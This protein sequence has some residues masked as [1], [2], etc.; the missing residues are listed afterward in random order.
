MRRS[1]RTTIFTPPISM[2][3]NA[4]FLSCGASVG[5][6]QSSGAVVY[7]QHV[8]DLLHGPGSGIS[9]EVDMDGGHGRDPAGPGQLP[10]RDGGAYTDTGAPW[11]VLRV[12]VRA[13]NGGRLA[14]VSAL[15]RLAAI[16]ERFLIAGTGSA[17][18]VPARHRGRRRP[19]VG[20]RS[21]ASTCG[22]SGATGMMSGPCQDR[23]WNP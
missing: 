11:P 18:G 9:G 2:L 10:D 16:A 5:I 6:P 19:G 4:I 22:L 14:L 23:A 21:L 17:G 1:W 7:A 3:A 20:D 13:G 8:F 15:K 12:A